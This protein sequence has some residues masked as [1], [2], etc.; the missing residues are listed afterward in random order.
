MSDGRTQK[1]EIE[2]ILATPDKGVSSTRGIGG[3]LARLWRVILSDLKVSP[4][5][6]EILLTDFITAAR[7]TPMENRVTLHLTRGNLRREL[8]KDTMTFNVFANAMRFLKFKSFKLVLVLRHATGR[9]TTHSIDVDLQKI[10][11]KEA[12]ATL[13]ALRE[14]ILADLNISE[15]RFELLLSQYIAQA[16][17]VA[18]SKEP[19]HT[20]RSGWRRELEKETMSFK[21]FVR[22]M[23]FLNVVQFRVIAELNHDEGHVSIHETAVDLGGAVTH[24]DIFDEDEKEKEEP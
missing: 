12:G 1:Y 11:I 2:K 17:K 10:K 21:T 23:R 9:H 5:R 16:K 7:K 6:F 19:R 3:I 22:L 14:R 8:G 24:Q 20:T 13:S 4:N 18:G 15:N